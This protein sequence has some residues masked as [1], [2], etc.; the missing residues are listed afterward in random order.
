[1][2]ARLEQS[3]YICVRESFNRILSYISIITLKKKKN[4]MI[5]IYISPV[6]TNKK[7][8]QNILYSNKI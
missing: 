7:I 3:H 8:A 1:M 5:L 2:P 6:Y 4:Y